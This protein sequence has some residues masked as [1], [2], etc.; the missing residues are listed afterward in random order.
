MPMTYTS[1]ASATPTSGTTVVVNKPSGTAD[2]DVLIAMVSVRGSSLPG[3]LTAPGGW[4][5]LTQYASGFARHGVFYKVAGASEGASYTF[6][7]DTT[8]VDAVGAIL[9][10]APSAPTTP[11]GVV[12]ATGYAT[13]ATPGVAPSV[14]ATG[15]QDTLIALFTTANTV[16][17]TPTGMTQRVAIDGGSSGAWIYDELLAAAGATGTRT[18]AGSGSSLA[19]MIALQAFAGGNRIRMMI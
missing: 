4:T 18:W 14:T 8:I 15:D 2:G 3:S 17:A 13:P 16:G 7:V 1:Q 19:W 9:R 6:T 10:Y 5:G 12:D 11:P